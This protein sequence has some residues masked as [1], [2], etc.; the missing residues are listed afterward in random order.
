MARELNYRPNRAAKMLLTNQSNTVGFVTMGAG[1]DQDVGNHVVYPFIIG[2]NSAFG[3]KGYHVTLVDIEELRDEQGV[4]LLPRLLQDQF[5]D[6]FILQKGRWGDI[7]EWIDRSLFPIILWDAGIF[8]TH[9]CIYRD[10]Y[11]VGWMLAKQLIGLGHRRLAFVTTKTDWDRLQARR[12]M[13]DLGGRVRTKGLIGLNLS[14]DDFHFSGVLRYEGM[15][16]AAVE[17]GLALDVIF[18]GTLPE[19]VRDLRER[20]P[21]A[22]ILEG[23]YNVDLQIARA[24]DALGWSI[25][26]R[27]SVAYCDLDIKAYHDANFLR[28]GGMTYDRF[29]A[30]GMAADMMFR[31]LATPGGKLPSIR[32]LGEF[33]RG[34]SIAP[35]P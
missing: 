31:A 24:A 35:A 4:T 25:P 5:C 11:Q 21:T 22:L 16:A 23:G 2:A 15:L 34:E 18:R 30:G 9:N 10:E 33:V 12:A 1:R 28:A 7:Q 20:S 27:L 19:L 8:K 29:Q 13:D 6:G 14:D 32:L 17:H 3:K 26:D